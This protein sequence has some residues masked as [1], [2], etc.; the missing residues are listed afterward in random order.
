MEYFFPIMWLVLFIVFIIIECIT[1]GL[2]T[3]WF[4]GGSVL[5]LFVAAVDGSL[6][7]Q[8]LVFTVVSLVLLIFTRPTLLKLMNGRLV[9]TNIETLEGEVVIVKETINNLEGVGTVFVNGMD[10]SAR[11]ANDDIIEAQSKAKVVK[12]EGVKLIVEKLS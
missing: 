3:I 10:W 7:I 12:I 4:A 6:L 1:Q 9:K 8:L 2:T 5:G 11:S